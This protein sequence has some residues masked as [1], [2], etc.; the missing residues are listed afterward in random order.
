MN[1]LKKIL[2]PVF[3][4]GLTGFSSVFAWWIDHFEVKMEPGNAKVWEALDL[5]IEAVDKNNIT[6]SDYN[7]T[8][9]IF[10]E[11]DPEAELPSVLEENTYTFSASDQWLIKFENGVSFKRA[12]TQ[13]VHIYDLEDDT[14]LWIAEVTIVKEV[15]ESNIDIGIIS[16]EDW[17]TIWE[18]K[19]NISWNTKKNYNV[20]III[21]WSREESTISNNEWLFEK[22]IENLENW[23]NTF[24]AQVLN[25]D[26]EIVWESNIVKIKVS[27][28]RPVLKNL[29]VIPNEVYPESEYKIELITNKWLTNVS[30]V[31]DNSI[32]KLEEEEEWVYVKTAYSPKKPNV[33]KIDVILKNELWLEVKE[34]W[35]WKLTVK[36]VEVIEKVELN[37]AKEKGIEVPTNN[38]DELL[39]TWLKLVELK[40]KSI[41]SWDKLEKA[42]SY[43]IYKKVADD[44]FELI[45]NVDTNKFE[46][47]IIWDEMKYDYFAVKAVWK[48]SSWE[49]YEW[50]LSDATKIQT[51]PELLILLILSILVWS[52]IFI[53]KSKKA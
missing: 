31:I 7:W 53:S 23:D 11:S 14:V 49:T 25:A 24:K 43:N 51:W 12:W 33:Y 9:L 42:E 44:K 30:V 48:K 39:I 38:D 35:S 1:T 28:E 26:N 34:L 10:S 2:V 45:E 18:Q 6:V 3:V 40:S 37:A 13:N 50:N 22:S 4:F 32:I 52:F 15:V 16:P 46:V 47:E 27:S 36:E 19:I 5:T 20:K 17:L 21:N 29:R 8:I 41:L